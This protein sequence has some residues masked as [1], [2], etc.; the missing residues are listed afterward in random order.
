MSEKWVCI[1]GH[2]YQPPRENPWLDAFWNRLRTMTGQKI[3]SKESAV[4]GMARVFKRNEILVILADLDARQSG[5]F[6]PFFL[7]FIFIILSI[8]FR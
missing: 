1:H 3:I 6:L 8:F 7:P 4:L 2:L 5:L